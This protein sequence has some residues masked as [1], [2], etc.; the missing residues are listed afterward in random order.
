M[1]SRELRKKKKKR[2]QN[3]S[4]RSKDSSNNEC[5][6]NLSSHSVH[7]SIDHQTSV[8]GN[9]TISHYIED[10]WDIPGE[11]EEFISP[12][13]DTVDRLHKSAQISLNMVNKHTN[14][15]NLDSIQDE[16]SL[17]KQFYKALSY[18][19]THVHKFY[20]RLKK[21]SFTYLEHVEEFR[22]SRIQLWE[23]AC[24]IYSKS[25]ED[26][27]CKYGDNIIKV[28]LSDQI[29]LLIAKVNLC[30]VEDLPNIPQYKMPYLVEN[31]LVMTR[32]PIL[33]LSLKELVDSIIKLSRQWNRLKYSPVLEQYEYLLEKK[34]SAFLGETHI[35]SMCNVEEF[36]KLV[37]GSDP[38]IFSPSEA[39][40]SMLC[41]YFSNFHIRL[42][43]M[44]VCDRVECPAEFR[45]SDDE[46]SRLLA[47]LKKITSQSFGDDVYTQY[48]ILY[49]PNLIP[50][51]Q[52]EEFTRKRPAD[53]PTDY[54]IYKFTYGEAMS[55]K[56]LDRASARQGVDILDDDPE[57]EPDSMPTFASIILGSA[58]KGMEHLSFSS[59]LITRAEVLQRRL[60]FQRETGPIIV[61]LLN[62]YDLYYDGK[63]YIFEDFLAATAAFFKILKIK[64]SLEIP[65]NGK[66][67]SKIYLDIF[68][69][70][71]TNP[72]ENSN[73][74]PSLSSMGL[75]DLRMNDP[76]ELSDGECPV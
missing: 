21:I 32:V 53:V 25:S 59:H 50:P 51:G 49:V 9:P 74:F 24:D 67:I 6:P 38:P 26:A 76:S 22:I 30:I 18:A 46:I 47:W 37:T 10:S 65:G 34:A 62:H 45:P 13:Y 36:R 16:V 31:S 8:D 20:V 52:R 56:M 23:K 17:V 5:L 41:A 15:R 71:E 12:Q 33:E 61:Q 1:K 4:E 35:G 40:I 19:H 7:Q 28:R 42:L 72:R 57:T 70:N 48:R 73:E 39:L 3:L 66:S 64:H 68:G 58:F 29:F 60:E 11:P 43:N 69:K 2:H 54:A 75:D 14:P 27:H 55:L 44:R 63:I